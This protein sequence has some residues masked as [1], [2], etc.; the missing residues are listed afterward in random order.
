MNKDS[1]THSIMFHHF[2]SETH[3]KGQGSISSQ[4]LEEMID[5]LEKKYN[6][7]SAEEYQNRLSKNQLEKDDICLSFDDGLLCQFDVA[8]PILNKKNI[9][10]FFFV[11]SSPINGT[12]NY[13]EIFRYFRTVAFGSIEEFYA[14]F[15]EKVQSIYGEKYY[16]E[17]KMFDPKDFLSN[18]P[19]YTYEDLWFRYLRDEVL[20]QNKYENLMLDIIAA[21]NYKIEDFKSKLWFTNDHLKKLVE[22]GHTVGLHSYTHPTSIKSL[23]KEEQKEEYIKNFNH[24]EGLLG[25]GYIKSMSHPCGSYD[26]TTLSLLDSLGIKIGFRN[27]M[28]VRLVKSSLEVPREDHANILRSMTQ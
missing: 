17:K 13:L 1:I 21:H 19:F 8:I 26:E 6:L 28:S 27:S 3:P 2:H 22:M 14:Q 18:S 23:S 24:L 16:A 5:W 20:K 4:Q 10:A 25:K 9:L 7:L 15:F 12:L 11:Y